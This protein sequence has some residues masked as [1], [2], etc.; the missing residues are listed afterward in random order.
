MAL[1]FGSLR[2]FIQE[3]PLSIA[4]LVF[5]IGLIAGGIVTL[6]VFSG[7]VGATFECIRV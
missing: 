5:L 4:V 2:S 6:T 3:W 7:V 1:F